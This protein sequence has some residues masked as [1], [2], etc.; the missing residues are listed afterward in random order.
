MS[1]RLDVRLDVV[2]LAGAVERQVAGPALAGQQLA[3]LGDVID[4]DQ[5][6]GDGAV[7][8]ETNRIAV[9]D[10]VESSIRSLLYRSSE[11]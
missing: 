9:G 6:L 4:P 1:R 8:V 2:V 5:P 11:D 7:D 3:E 10:L